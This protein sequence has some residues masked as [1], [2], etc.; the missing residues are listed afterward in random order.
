MS[1]DT[2]EQ[3]IDQTF[4][5]L[6]SDSKKVVE[7]KKGGRTTPVTWDSRLEYSTL[8]YHYYLHEFDIPISRIRNGISKVCSL[9]V[10]HL[11]TWE[12]FDFRV[13]GNFGV[14]LALL[15]RHTTYKYP[16]TENSFLIEKLWSVL[17]SFSFEEQ[18][19]FL[20]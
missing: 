7:L 5:T 11:F 9:D 10:F 4:T 16:L 15:R 17:N 12:E 3:A 13:C 2:F 6:S 8:V 1:R 18:T 14:D 19:L 20:R